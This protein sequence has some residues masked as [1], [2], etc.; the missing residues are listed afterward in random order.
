LAH[1][2]YDVLTADIQNLMESTTKKC[3]DDLIG[4]TG[5]L[6]LKILNKSGWNNELWQKVATIVR[7]TTPRP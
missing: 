7:H 6:D 5:K 3:G 4:F 2:Q 1:K